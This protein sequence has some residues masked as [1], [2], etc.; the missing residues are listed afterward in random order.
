MR[1]IYVGAERVIVWLGEEGNARQALQSLN[2]LIAQADQIP[3]DIAKRIWE[4]R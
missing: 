3:V 2:E 1:G 4:K